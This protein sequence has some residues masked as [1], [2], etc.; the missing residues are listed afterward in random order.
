VTTRSEGGGDAGG[1]EVGL[2]AGGL[3]GLA[4]TGGV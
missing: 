1:L 2:S 4:V 3:V